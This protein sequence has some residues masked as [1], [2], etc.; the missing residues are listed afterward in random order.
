[1]LAII[2]SVNSINTLA[3]FQY[4]EKLQDLFVRK[5]NI[6]DLNEVCYLKD[7]TYLKSLF[8]DENPCVIDA[9]DERYFFH[10]TTS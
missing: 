1:M 6:R 7:L 5:N 10:D 4:C 2:F 3:D 8:L 9:R